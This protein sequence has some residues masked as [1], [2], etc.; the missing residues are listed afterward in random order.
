MAAM[1]IDPS[2]LREVYRDTITT[3]PDAALYRK[4]AD[5]GMAT[6]PLYFC[7]ESR[8][9]GQDAVKLRSE[10]ARWIHKACLAKAA[11]K[12][13]GSPTCR[14]SMLAIDDEIVLACAATDGDQS[15]VTS[16]LQHGIQSSPLVF[17]KR[18]PLLAAA[19][20]GH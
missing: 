2:T 15:Q 3:L 10:C 7:M 16:L 19:K 8:E 4:T 13:G 14:T 20:A 1:N 9:I 6:E 5:E 12:T 18:T 17:A 11:F